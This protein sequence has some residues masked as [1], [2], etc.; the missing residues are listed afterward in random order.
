LLEAGR[1]PKIRLLAYSEVEAFSG[2]AGNFSVTIRKKARYVDENKC[3]GCGSCAEKCPTEVS[4]DFNMGL[5]KRKAIYKYFAQGIP[6]VFTIDTRFCRQFTGKKC[7]V[8]KKTC[9]AGAVDYEQQ[10]QVLNL[11]VGAVVVAIGYELFD[12]GRIPEYGY[13][14]LPNVI[15][16]LEFER[17]LSASGPTHGHVERPSD[18]K[19]KARLAGLTKELQRTQRAL[20]GYEKKAGLASAEFFQKFLA[21]EVKGNGDAKAWAD[22]YQ[23]YLKTKEETD[24]L[25]RNVETFSLAKRLA[26]IQCVGSRDFRFHP[27]CSS[28]CCMHTIKEAIIAKEHGPETESTVFAMDLR[29]VGK[30]FEE[31]KLR[32]ASESGIRYVRSRVAEITQDGEFNPIVWYEDTKSRLVQSLPFDLVIL[33]NACVATPGAYALAQTLGVDLD[34]NNFLKTD[35]LEPLSTNVPGIFTCGCAQGPMDIPES[36]A[37]ASSA[38]AKAAEVVL[39]C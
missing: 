38:A 25:T 11:E 35:P 6:S 31:Y 37:Q 21:Q 20:E 28:Y 14:K 4:D 15:S 9:Q 29:T 18:L 7:G 33:A 23:S 27:Y 8:C 22:K 17:L 16:A 36:V 1:H 24:N 12:A 10:D 19:A 26:F 32:G 34:Q 2:Q 39:K 13:Q 30:G 3:T 5:A